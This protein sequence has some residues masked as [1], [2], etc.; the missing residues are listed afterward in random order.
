M[1]NFTFG[2]FQVPFDW[3]PTEELMLVT[4]EI[5]IISK[6]ITLWQSFLF[7]GFSKLNKIATK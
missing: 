7:K 3:S 4:L 6:R 5:S 1:T 2:I